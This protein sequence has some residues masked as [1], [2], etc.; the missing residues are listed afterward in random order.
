MSGYQDNYNKSELVYSNDIHS[1]YT[2]SSIFD[3]AQLSSTFVIA[4]GC[5]VVILNDITV[6]DIY[7]AC[8][9]VRFNTA[10][11]ATHW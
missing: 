6:D 8:Y 9:Y 4:S 11:M 10:I 7:Q 1:E 3:N 5:Y 2:S